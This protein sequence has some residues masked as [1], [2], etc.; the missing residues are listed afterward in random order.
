M[1][2]WLRIRNL[3]V[4]EDLTWELEPGFNIL[5]GETGA[6]KSILI[7]A[8]NLLLGERADKTLV[9]DG[10]ESCSVEALIEPNEA[11]HALLRE[12]EHEPCGDEGL[13][14]KRVFTAQGQNRQ[15]VNGSPVTLQ[16]LKRLGDVLADLHGPHDHQSL[17]SPDLQLAALDAYAGLEEERQ[18]FRTLHREQQA[19]TQE[20]ADLQQ[21]AGGDWQRQ[22][23]F[24][25]YQIAEIEE[26]A[27][28]EGEEE[29]LHQEYQ[30]ATHGRRI[31]EIGA[32]VRM[33]LAEDEADIL[34]RLASVEKLLQEWEKLDP[35]SAE[36]HEMN[37]AAITQLQELARSVE[38]RLEQVD[39]DGQRL[40]E[41][42]VRIN[43]IQSLRRK[44]G[45]TIADILKKLGAMKKDR[46]A[47]AGREGTIQALQSRL[48]AR[49]KTMRA[50]AKK[51]S[52]ARAKAAPQLASRITA[53][54]RELGFK[55]AGFEIRLESLEAFK[56][57][58][59]DAVEFLFSPNP[60]EGTRPLRAIASSGEMARVM[61]AVK[62]V[63][64]AQDGVMILIFDEV[65]ANV[66]GE[67]AV[68]VG[69]KLRE[70]AS[71]HQV[72]CITHLPQVAAAGHVHY[73]VEKK[74]AG[75]RTSAKLTRLDGD[76]RLAE[77]ARMLG[78]KNHP[79]LVLAK[80]LLA[81]S[82]GANG[83]K[84]K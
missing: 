81:E 55:Q 17:L 43:L 80:E 68:A 40:A 2:R 28:K 65:D 76:D 18:A 60:G 54:L 42:E 61:L 56:P 7:D 33:A 35:T 31:V 71:S 13:I 34:T 20:L 38:R 16:N 50:A 45:N 25:D 72:L 75:G 4:I 9:R 41:L 32:A 6:G 29:T 64:A 63:L 49:E 12:M 27:L 48:A 53:Q 84:K 26:A 11:V 5:T 22:V 58:G 24:L 15:M 79:A 69:R 67:T 66:G 8:F 70:L 21:A 36:L 10:A 74:V 44:H 52:N 73:A 46:D 23:E 78:G 51:L 19:E 77:L 82:A 62:T 37:S 14:L 39:L 30:V 57:S 83:K 47:L 59:L 3:A 1:L